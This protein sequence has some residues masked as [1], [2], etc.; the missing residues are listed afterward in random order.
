M[1]TVYILPAGY[2]GKVH[3]GPAGPSVTLTKEAPVSLQLPSSDV[4]F[5]SAAIA[6]AGGVYAILLGGFGFDGVEGVEEVQ[7]KGG[8]TV[9]QHPEEAQF[10]YGPQKAIELGIADEIIF[11]DKLAAHLMSYRNQNVY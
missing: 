6:F 7:A 10:P 11:A 1:G 8:V 3:R 5:K 2:H 9:V 4:L